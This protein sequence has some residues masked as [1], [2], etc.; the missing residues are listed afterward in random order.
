[1][2]S[3]ATA[4]IPRRRKVYEQRHPLLYRPLVEFMA[5]VPWEQKLRPR[6]DRYL[7]RRALEGVL[8]EL[9]RRRA[10]KGNGNPAI[11]E[12]L[13]RSRDWI[14][15]LCDDPQLA[16]RGIVDRERWRTVVRQASVGQ[17]HDD[18]NFLAAVAVEVWLKQLRE[19]AVR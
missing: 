19:R 1:M 2:M 15:Y 11:V 7:Q 8:P 4:L 18:K 3:I 9:I 17:T 5:G 16:Q 6:C 13:R 10:T 14:A 12:G